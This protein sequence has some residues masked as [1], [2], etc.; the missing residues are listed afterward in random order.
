MAD[1]CRVLRRLRHVR[2]LKQSH[3]AEL[4]GVTQA[5][6]SRWERGAARPAAAE[7]ARLEALLCAPADPAAD[8]ALK[9]LV[10]TSP[11]PV[12]LIC[13][14]THRLLA[15]SPSRQREWCAPAARFLG[16][17][18]FRYASDEIRDHEARLADLG[19]Y[20]SLAPRLVFHT[21]ANESDEIRILPSTMMWE[22]LALSDGSVARLVTSL[23]FDAAG[24]GGERAR[25]AGMMLERGAP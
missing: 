8:R 13:D 7:R 1:L 11:D 18:L 2:G 20:D 17:P 21:G 4:L 25:P 3:L 6:V 14:V 24:E 19:W 16:E 23:A 15:A 5:T 12:H 9:R 10:E 22:R